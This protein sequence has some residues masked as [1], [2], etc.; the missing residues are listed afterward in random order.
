MIFF[1][2]IV[3]KRNEEEKECG[4]FFVKVVLFYCGEI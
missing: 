1:S 2:V 3:G 4:I